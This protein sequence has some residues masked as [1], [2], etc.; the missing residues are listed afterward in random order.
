MPLADAFRLE[1]FP[2]RETAIEMY[3]GTA[4]DNYIATVHF[5]GNFL[6]K[7]LYVVIV[8]TACN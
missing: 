2:N 8:A 7:K 6:M 5:L 1:K 4:S 3:S